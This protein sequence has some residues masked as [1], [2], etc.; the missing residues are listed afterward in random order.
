MFFG[1]GTIAR[2]CKVLQHR[3]PVIPVHDFLPYPLG[4]YR[5]DVESGIFYFL[6]KTG[7]H[8]HHV[9]TAIRSDIQRTAYENRGVTKDRAY[10]NLSELRDIQAGIASGFAQQQ[11]CCCDTLRAIDGVNMLRFAAANAFLI[12]SGTSPDFPKP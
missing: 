8:P 6:Y 11:K 7:L 10:N 2:V 4:I 3:L 9:N 5:E 1:N 12:A